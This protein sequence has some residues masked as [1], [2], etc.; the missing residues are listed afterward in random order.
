MAKAP[1]LQAAK[2]R[3]C[4]D[5][6]GDIP[7]RDDIG[8]DVHGIEECRTPLQFQTRPPFWSFRRAEHIR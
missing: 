5:E 8:D 1:Y 2:E 7:Y 4:A 6:D 3:K